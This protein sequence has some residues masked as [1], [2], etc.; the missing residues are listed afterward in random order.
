MTDIEVSGECSFHISVKSKGNNDVT[1]CKKCSEYETQLKEALDELISIRMMNELLQKELLSYATSKSRWGIDPDSTDNNIQPFKNWLLRH[2][3][4]ISYNKV[5]AHKPYTVT[6][7]RFQL[8]DNHQEEDSPE[9]VPS[10]YKRMR[11]QPTI[12]EK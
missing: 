1:I 8:L 5:A 12:C 2:S 3:S 11:N 6:K 4:K 9:E 10:N 7:N